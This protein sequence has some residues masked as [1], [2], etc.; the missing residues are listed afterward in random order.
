MKIHRRPPEGAAGLLYGGGVG[1]GVGGRTHGSSSW[2]AAVAVTL[3]VVVRLVTI[4]ST[5]A[6]TW[7][8]PGGFDPVHA[9]AAMFGVGARTVIDVDEA[10]WTN[11]VCA[12]NLTSASPTVAGRLTPVIVTRVPPGPIAGEIP[13]IAGFGMT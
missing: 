7:S 11:A 12:P 3:H 2:K 13:V 1:V 6:T 4:T 9:G 8:V 10:D 5:V